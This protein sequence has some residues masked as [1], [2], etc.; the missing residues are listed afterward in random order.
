MGDMM[1]HL[2]RTDLFKKMLL[3]SILAGGLALVTACGS[4]LN[5]DR[6]H[7]DATQQ[8]DASPVSPG[9][10]KQ[11]PKP[12]RA[13]QVTIEDGRIVANEPAGGGGNSPAAQQ[14]SDAN[15]L[16]IEAI[17]EICIMEATMAKL[18][19]DYRRSKGLSALFYEPKVAYAA[20]EWSKKSAQRGQ[21][22][23]ATPQDHMR[24][25]R[26][27]FPGV[28]FNLAAENMAYSPNYYGTDLDKAAAGI[29]K[30]WIDDKPHRDN[31]LGNFRASGIG[32]HFANGS[33]WV[34]Q[35]FLW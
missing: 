7:L 11:N 23:H 4:D 9:A 24:V 5:N 25:L 22:V 34:T 21:V 8:K 3:L 2:I 29:V 35:V 13:D 18:V 14:P 26:L 15:S 17:N 16:C 20:R 28:Q 32:V 6:R 19:N 1:L 31:L 30:L 10:K 33:W 27:K 12:D